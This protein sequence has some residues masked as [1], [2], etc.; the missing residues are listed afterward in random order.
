MEEYDDS[1]DMLW[2]NKSLNSNLNSF[3]KF[4][5]DVFGLGHEL[6]SLDL[7]AIHHLGPSK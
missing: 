5:N 3:K 1:W 2:I 6:P 4:V 7:D